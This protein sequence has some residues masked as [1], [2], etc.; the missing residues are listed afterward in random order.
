MNRVIAV[1]IGNWKKRLIKGSGTGGIIGSRDKEKDNRKLN[2]I[3][4]HTI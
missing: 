3:K 1:V 4:I 2:L